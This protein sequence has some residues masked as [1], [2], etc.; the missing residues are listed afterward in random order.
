MEKGT[1]A[2]AASGEAVEPRELDPIE[3][4]DEDVARDPRHPGP[5]AGDRGAL[6]AGRRAR[7]ASARPR[8]IARLESLRERNGLRRVAAILFHRR[9]GFSANGMG[10]WEVPEG[11]ILDTGRR[12][13]AFRGI[14]HCYQRPTYAGL[15]LLG[16]H[17]GPRPL[18][19][20]VRRGAR[21]DRRADRHHRPRD[22]LLEHRVQED[23]DALLHRRVPA[24]GKREHAA[25]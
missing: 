22:A 15:A 24:T 14:S 17:D 20:G 4:S 7:S 10:V 18:E 13:A 19:G 25:S 8:C 21:R 2:L 9:A 1:E 11:E 6:R 12:M 5:D 16:V 23:P 3:L